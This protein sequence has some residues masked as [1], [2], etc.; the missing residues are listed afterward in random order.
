MNIELL[1]KV[2]QFHEKVPERFTMDYWYEHDFPG[3]ERNR[4]LAPVPVCGTI[5]CIAGTVNILAGNCESG[6]DKDTGL[7]RYFDP[8]DGW[9]TGAMKALD[10][11]KEQAQRLFFHTREIAEANQIEAK[12]W[13]DNFSTA[14]LKATTAKERVEVLKARVAHFIATDGQK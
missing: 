3:T 12:Y 8:D 1:N 9:F 13:P 5:G 4:L 2:V 11:T 10:L 6:E 14:Y 7:T